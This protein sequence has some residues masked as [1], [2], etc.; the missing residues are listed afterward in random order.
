MARVCCQSFLDAHFNGKSAETTE[1]VAELSGSRVSSEE[2]GKRPWA[3]SGDGWGPTSSPSQY[4]EAPVP[5]NRVVLILSPRVRE[6]TEQ[7]ILVNKV[8]FQRL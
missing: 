8:I 1:H 7:L 6:R 3:R 5:A 4:G 2:L